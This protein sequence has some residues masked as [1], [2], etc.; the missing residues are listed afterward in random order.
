MKK[1]CNHHLQAFNKIKNMFCMS[2]K[3]TFPIHKT[4]LAAMDAAGVNYTR[5][6]QGAF[7]TQ[8]WIALDTTD[9]NIMRFGMAMENH[10]TDKALVSI[11]HVGKTEEAY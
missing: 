8:V 6:K 11:I 2:T 1:A 9:T 4:K 7:E 10:G 3:V 5:I